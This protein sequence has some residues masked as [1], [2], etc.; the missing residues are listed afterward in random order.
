[1][2]VI[3]T[4]SDVEVRTL[5]ARGQAVVHHSDLRRSS[6]SR[7]LRLLVDSG[8]R[9]RARI[10]DETG[11]NKATV[12][13]VVTELMER[14][15]VREGG[16]VRGG[17]GRPG[18]IV[19][20]ERHAACGIGV[21]IDVDGLRGLGRDLGGEVV[22]QTHV[23]LDVPRLEPDRVLDRLADVIGE[24]ATSAAR[25]GSRPVGVTVGL[26]GGVH[27]ETGQLAYAPNL[28][29]SGAWRAL[30]L[31]EQ[32]S[33]RLGT[34]SLRVTVD[35]EANLAAVAEGATRDGAED[36]MLL[37][38]GVGVGCG[39]LVDGVPLRGAHGYAGEVGHM[40]LAGDGMTCG[41]GRRGCWESVVGLDALL[42]AAADP[43]D[44]V[45]DPG[46]S[47]AARLEM[48]AERA[49][50]GDARTLAALTRTG[51]WLG[52]GAAVL[53]NVLNPP[54]LVL[55]G[56][57]AVLGPWLVEPV[58]RALT[59]RVIA[60]AAGGC[61]VQTS[62]LGFAA[63]ELGGAAVALQ[64]VL[65]DPGSLPARPAPSVPAAAGGAR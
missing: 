34:A 31:V 1:L 33:Q 2:P 5:P 59:E 61:R 14:G 46:R 32:V 44:P 9:S 56:Y 57:F 23:P 35:N 45:R 26:P 11:L 41:C 43:D 3:A 47:L 8:P 58:Q 55:G 54:L 50:A 27:P 49:R 51:S 52:V 63:T 37:T 60:P 10:A 15:L 64:A 17:L 21:A 6:L 25:T 48:L 7:V 13:S 42:Q 22:A 30:R 16:A 29:H 20:V 18:Q 62:A 4:K 65:D 24:L 19:E 28:D 36:L 12:S 40:P 39:I 53:V 38:G